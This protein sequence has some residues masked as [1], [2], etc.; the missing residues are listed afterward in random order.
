MRILVTGGA[1]YIGSHTCVALLQA[2]YSVRTTMRSPG[3][4]A[5]LR[6]AL[7]AAGCVAGARLL[8]RQADLMADDG[9]REAALGCE[10]VLHVASPLSAAAPTSPGRQ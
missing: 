7:A 10:R 3:R 5:A 2:G 8:V 1:G 9:W 4:E 6:A